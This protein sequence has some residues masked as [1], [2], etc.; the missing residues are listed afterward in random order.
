MSTEI[1]T[2]C[3]VILAIG[4]ILGFL[5]GRQSMS[6][7]KDGYLYVSKTDASMIHQLEII[8]PPDKLK[9]QKRVV[10]NVQKVSQ[11]Q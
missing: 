1:S 11:E 9:D 4:L 2:I 5:L 7:Q 3:S 10:F 8:T 6:R